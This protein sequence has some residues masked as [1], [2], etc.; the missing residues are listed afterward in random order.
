MPPRQKQGDRPRT[1]RSPFGLRPKRP[2]P[3]PQ[4]SPSKIVA[5]VADLTESSLVRLQLNP[6]WALLLGMLL[7]SLL[8]TPVW[9]LLML[10]SW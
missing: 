2:R 8:L 3:N 7:G 1:P 6:T 9:L 4:P 10:A 5:M